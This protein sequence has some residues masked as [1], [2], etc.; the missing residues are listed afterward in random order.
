RCGWT[1]RAE[2]TFGSHHTSIIRTRNWSVYWGCSKLALRFFR[3]THEQYWDAGAMPDVMNGAAEDEVA[4]QAMAVAGHGDQGAT[5]GFSNLDDFLRRIS[6]CQLRSG[7]QA[8]LAKTCRDFFEV[9]AVILHLLGFGEF[10]LVKIAGHPAIGDMEQQ[11]FRTVQFRQ[12]G[13]VG[14]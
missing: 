14:Q 13:N 2:I 5:L 1:V 11:K 4:N 12:R 10:E 9:G 8:L 7:R 6:Q 3:R